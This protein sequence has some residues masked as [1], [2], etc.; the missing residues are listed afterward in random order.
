MLGSGRPF[1]IE[2]QNARLSPSDTSICEIERR[3]NCLESRHVSCVAQSLPFCV[4]GLVIVKAFNTLLHSGY[5]KKS[6]G[7]R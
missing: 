6:Q 4:L 3:I 7:L 1:L 5:G 2:V